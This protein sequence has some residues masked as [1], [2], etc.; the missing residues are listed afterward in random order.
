MLS[1]KHAGGHYMHMNEY[2]CIGMYFSKTKGNRKC[3]FFVALVFFP[4]KK[5]QTTY[6]YMNASL[7]VHICV[8]KS[9]CIIHGFAFT[10]TLAF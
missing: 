8:Y 6:A 7:R 1:Y 9:V 10:L 4:K 5:L 3:A 2:A